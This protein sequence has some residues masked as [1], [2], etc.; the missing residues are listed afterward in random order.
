MDTSI[1]LA[2]L[3]PCDDRISDDMPQLDL[4]RK[5]LP[6]NVGI[7]EMPLETP[8]IR[9]T[10]PLVTILPHL[11]AHLSSTASEKVTGLE[12]SVCSLLSRVLLMEQAVLVWTSA[13]MC[14]VPS[15]E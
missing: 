6:A 9:D 12:N 3:M 5:M 7:C 8:Y 10:A 4:A 2:L 1:L 14:M 15:R 13:L 11:L